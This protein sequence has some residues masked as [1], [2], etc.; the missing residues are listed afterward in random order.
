[1]PVAVQTARRPGGGAEEGA[2]IFPDQAVRIVIATKLRLPADMTGWRPWRMPSWLC[3]QGWGDG[4]LQ[5]QT[6]RQDQAFCSGTAGDRVMIYKRLEQG[7]F[8][9]QRL[10]TGSCGCRGCSSRR[11][12]QGLTGASMRPDQ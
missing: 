8:V 4:C 9:S 7:G 2:V 11:C 6:W 3:A 5:V 1:M 10:A 12:L